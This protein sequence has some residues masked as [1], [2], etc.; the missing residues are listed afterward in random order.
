MSL[1]VGMLG[2]LSDGTLGNL[3]LHWRVILIGDKSSDSLINLLILLK[4]VR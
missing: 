4:V 1:H 3:V 2:E